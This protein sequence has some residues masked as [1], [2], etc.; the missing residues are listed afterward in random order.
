[1]AALILPHWVAVP[2]ESHLTKLLP[3]GLC[4]LTMS[5][6]FKR[7][8]QAWDRVGLEDVFTQAW[9]DRG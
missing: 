3:C 2:S 5:V 1:M 4:V 6:K 9:T 8:E 7:C